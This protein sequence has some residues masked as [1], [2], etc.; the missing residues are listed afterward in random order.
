MPD[1]L[2]DSDR[3]A[4]CASFPA[5]SAPHAHAPSA[6]TLE[7]PVDAGTRTCVT[8]D[9]RA[10]RIEVADRIPEGLAESL[11]V[12]RLDD[13]INWGR[14]N[15]LWPMFFGLSCCFVETATSITARHDISRFGAEV[16]RGSPRQ[17]D[18]MIVAGTVFK[19]M[20]SAVIRLYE[21]MLE[22]RW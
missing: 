7:P 9:V 10:S 6:S 3:A 15:S 14:A 2:V 18:V 20:A 22:P 13:L 4:R 8:I 16:M 17:S 1:R 12:A 21:Q 19:K 5:E 11:V